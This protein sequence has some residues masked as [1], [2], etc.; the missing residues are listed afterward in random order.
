[1]LSRHKKAYFYCT[2]KTFASSM[3]RMAIVIGF[4]LSLTLGSAEAEAQEDPYYE[5]KTLTLYVGR[6]PG[7]GADLAARVFAQFWSQYIPGE[8][9]VIVRNL[10]GGAE[11]GCGIMVQRWRQATVSTY[12]FR[13]RM[14][15]LR[16]LRSRGCVQTFLQCRLWGDY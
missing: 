12:S 15:L 10:P 14:V 5:G 1:M 13:P 9:T 3:Q 11:H 6:T 8:P 4:F 16:F 7:S 2:K